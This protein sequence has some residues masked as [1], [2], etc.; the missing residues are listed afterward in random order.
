[1]ITN[2]QYMDTCLVKKNFSSPKSEINDREDVIDRYALKK[3]N[4]KMSLIC[5]L[6]QYNNFP[7][8]LE[9][10]FPVKYSKIVLFSTIF[11]PKMGFHMIILLTCLFVH[12]YIYFE[13]FP[14]KI[15]CFD[16]GFG[17]TTG[18]LHNKNSKWHCFA[19]QHSKYS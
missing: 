6:P 3:S 9:F 12:Y 8:Y 5:C 16:R 7:A 1:M 4:L 19:R 14:S 2:M 17:P 15:N 13:Y 11:S 18:I 10:F